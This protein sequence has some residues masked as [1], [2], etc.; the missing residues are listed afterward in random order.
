LLKARYKVNTV[1][2]RNIKIGES[3]AAAREQKDGAFKDATQV[4]VTAGTEAVKFM[5]ILPLNNVIARRS[6]DHQ[7][8]EFS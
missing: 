4:R 5:K 1:R 6:H 3:K 7:N 8:F 2:L